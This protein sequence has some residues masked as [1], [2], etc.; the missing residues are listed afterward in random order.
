MAVTQSPDVV[1]KRWTLDASDEFAVAQGCWFDE[2]RGQF[3][4][5]WMRDYL[6]LYE[7]EAAG[8]PFECRDWQY[9]ATMR[10]FGWV[11][12]SED[13]GR[14][15][16]RFSKA[17]IFVAKKNKKSPQLAAWCV[18]MFAGD[19][20]MGQKCFPTAVDG[21]QIKENV[22]R[23]IHEMIRQSDALNAECKINKTT[24]SVFHEPTRSLILPL[25]SDNVRTQKAKEGLNG[26]LFVDEVHVV[27]K[28][29]MRRISRA[30]ISRPE[31]MHIE[32][33]TAGDEPESYGMGR[34]RYAESIIAGATR[35]ITTLAI[36]HAA[37][38]DVTDEQIH[39]D[40]IKYGRLANPAWGHTVKQTEFLN[41]YERSK[42]TIAE[43]ADFKKY[44]LNIWQ[45][46]TNPW[47][48]VHDWDACPATDYELDSGVPTYGG[49]DLSRT[50]D[51]TAWIKYQ[52]GEMP[53]CWGHYWCPRQRAIELSN[54]FEIPLLDWAEQGWVTLS[55]DRVIDR[56]QVH[57]Y[58]RED[59]DEYRQLHYAGYDP[60]NADDTVKFCIDELYWEMVELRQGTA[61]LNAPSKLLEEMVLSAGLD[62]SNDPVLRWMLQNTAVRFDENGNIKPIKTVGGVR[63]HID[64]VVALIMALCVALCN[65]PSIYE[66]KG[67]LSL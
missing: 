47:I 18:Y 24:G 64:G 31:P 8:Q 55:D 58:L 48:S 15:I 60:W 22:G 36:I 45:Q 66:S 46:S 3:V 4:V 50:T 62:H 61:T 14:T 29:H 30:G 19:G 17:I 7:G 16:R 25:S 63:K 56:Y 12:D 32:A 67:S 23:H 37:P 2:A 20:V 54:Q 33:S 10:L 57:E 6:I 53:K 40:P 51:L 44:R 65:P 42:R 59:A 38:Q 5:D 27:N 35:D 26:S 9:D 39:A 21:A 52:P 49:L 43:F 34:F 1:T 28:E 13:W 11:R 41:D